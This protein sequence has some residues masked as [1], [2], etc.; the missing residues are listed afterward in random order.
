MSVTA[1]KRAV[2]VP[3]KNRSGAGRSADR[4]QYNVGLPPRDAEVV[5]RVASALGLDGVG[6]IRMVLNEHIAEY[7]ARADRIEAARKRPGE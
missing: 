2:N 5:D 7:V 6:L 1:T 4:K 3:Q